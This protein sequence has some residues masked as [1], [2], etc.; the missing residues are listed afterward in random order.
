MLRRTFP[1]LFA[2]VVFYSSC[3]K[4]ATAPQYDF[5]VPPSACDTSALTWHQGIEKIISAN[6]SYSPNTG[7][8]YTGEGN[9]DFTSYEVVAGRIRSGRFTERILLTAEHPLSMPPSGYERDSIYE[10]H[11]AKLMTWIENG[12]PEN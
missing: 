7:C 11:F 12:F 8:H 5:V 6:C 2:V 4:D 3:S 1:A 10:C 9:Y